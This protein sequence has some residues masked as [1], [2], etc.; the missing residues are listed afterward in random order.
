VWSHPRPSIGAHIWHC[1]PRNWL[2]PTPHIKSSKNLR[3]QTGK[4]G[5]SNKMWG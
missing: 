5:C 1:E 4:L 3:F 2:R